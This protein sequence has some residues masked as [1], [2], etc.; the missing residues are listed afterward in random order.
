MLLFVVIDSIFGRGHNEDEL[1]VRRFEELGLAIQ[2]LLESVKCPGFLG[3]KVKGEDFIYL[4]KDQGVSLY[5]VFE[6]K[7]KL[8]GDLFE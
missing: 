1:V 7:H 6:L 5:A 4:S 3:H 2:L 8:H